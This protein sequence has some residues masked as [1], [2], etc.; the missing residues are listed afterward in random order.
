MDRP[1]LCGVLPLL[2]DVGF[3]L[4]SRGDELGK[5]VSTGLCRNDNVVR[6]LILMVTGR[7]PQSY[8]SFYPR[9]SVCGP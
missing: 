5:R 9:A 6:S 1:P 4:E 8:A 7:F 3:D 2:L